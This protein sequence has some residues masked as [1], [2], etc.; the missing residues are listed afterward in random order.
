[1]AASFRNLSREGAILQSLCSNS[2]SL[3]IFAAIR[4]AL[5]QAVATDATPSA[6]LSNPEDELAESEGPRVVLD[7][8]RATPVSSS[9]PMI[10]GKLLNHETIPEDSLHT[11]KVGT[12]ERV[13][14]NLI[15]VDAAEWLRPRG[16]GSCSGPT[17][18]ERET[19]Q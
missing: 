5:E 15:E 19:A 3:A 11:G 9:S 1:M 18:Q 16:V 17:V 10:L 14:R 4:R 2:G 12:L 8:Y 7:Y 6:R 13:C